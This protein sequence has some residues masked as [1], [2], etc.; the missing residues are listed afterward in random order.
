MRPRKRVVIFSK[1]EDL[2]SVLAY[3][4]NIWG[5]SWC[6]FHATWAGAA[7]A[8]A[9]ASAEEFIEVVIAIGDHPK[10]L[11][12]FHQFS[13]D[14]RILMILPTTAGAP[15]TRATLTLYG[16]SQAEI[17]DALTILAARKRGP[18]KGM[19]FPRHPQPATA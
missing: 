9:A 2:G 14:T 3:S 6:P 4:I 16:P 5:K 17:R 11:K 10:V 18:K 1:D 8:L 7:K 13:S 15:V 12:A 19:Y